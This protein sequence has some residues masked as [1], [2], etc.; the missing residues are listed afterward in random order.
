MSE[1]TQ[2][3]ARAW[4]DEGADLYAAGRYAEAEAAT[5]QAL[6]LEPGNLG[7]LSNLGAMLRVQR[8]AAEALA[9]FEQGLAIAPDSAALRVNHA[10]LLNDLQRWGEALASA[11]AACAAAPADGAAHAARGQALAGLGR[12]EDA[13]EAFVQAMNL[14]PGQPVIGFNL[15]KTLFEMNRPDDAMAVYAELA[16]RLPGAPRVQ[17]E[18]GHAFAMLGRWA[19]AAEAYG[20]AYALA[21]DLP[22]LLGQLLMS[23]QRI[24]DWTDFEALS[25]DLAR[26]IEAGQPAA[27][28]LPTAALP[29]TRR[30]QLLCARTYSAQ[31]FAL[32]PRDLAPPPGPRLRVGYF[33]ADFHAHATAFLMAEM[34]EL[35]DRD[36]FEVTLFSFGPDDESPMRGRIQAAAERFYDVRR[37]GAHAIAEM[38]RGLPLDIAVDL[39]GFTAGSRPEIF[40]GRAAPVQVSFLG[41]PMTSG[42]PFLDYLVADP[43]LIAPPKRG[44]MGETADYSEKIAW[45]P[46]CYQPNDRKREISDRVTTRAD[47]GLPDDS[48]VFASFNG[49]FKIAPGVFSLWMEMLR[50]VPGAVLWLL[51]DEPVA[52]ANLKAAAK[53][54]GVDPARLVFAP[55]VVLARHLERLRHADLFLDSLPYGAHTTASDALWAGLPLVTRKGE[56]FAGRVAASLLTAAGLPELIVETWDAYKGLA[57]GLARDPD[58]VASV[59][60]RVAAARA[61]SPLFDTPRY[62]ANLEALYRRMHERRLAGLAPDHLP[63]QPA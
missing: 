48:F 2:K 36:T 27:T 42:A 14:A 22:H 9:T 51:G 63:P 41:F 61:A 54:A 33:S 26:R 5:R 19:E 23:R 53:G 44:E 34:L 11:E 40:A 37:L 62:V 4:L 21:P 8:R 15:A 6:K 39:K 3:T 57:L 38:A 46:D 52:A 55:P 56:T 32:A 10:N 60:A 28:P 7:A 20:K 24:C 29:I 49:S 50:E 30:Q 58:R 13:V 1:P 47:H 12:R 35:H 43:V 16:A 31:T 25:T 18:R 45:L 59:R 17:A